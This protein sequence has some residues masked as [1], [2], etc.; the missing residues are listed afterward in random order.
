MILV[1]DN[2]D[3]FTFN[4][5]ACLRAL[6]EEVRVHRHDEVT[7]E[8]AIAARPRAILLSPGPGT[9]ADAGVCLDLV[10]RADG[11]VP[12]L[13][14]C[15]GHQVIAAALGGRIVR[16]PEPVHGKTSLIEHDGRTLFSGLPRP[17]AAT[18]YHSLAVDRATLPPELEISAWTQ[19]GTVMAIRHRERSLEGVQFHP[20]SIL[21]RDGERLLGNWLRSLPA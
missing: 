9:P 20:E 8:A 3:S 4:L 18:R 21:T 11:R 15:L 2:Y 5:V 7:P 19:D 6:G 13:G 14:V 12:V 16:A 17:F 1:V 10:R